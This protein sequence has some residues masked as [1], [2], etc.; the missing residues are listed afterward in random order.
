MNYVVVAVYMAI[1]IGIGWYAKQRAKT[2]S[3][4]LVAGRRLGPVLYGGTMGALVM[5]GGATVGGIGLG[6]Q[7]GISGMWLAFS[8]G[9]GV[10]V[11]SLTI[12][13][14]VSRLKVYTVSQMLEL[15]YGKGAAVVSGV[16]MLGY[17]FMISVTSTIAYGTIFEVLFGIGKAPAVIFGGGVV[18]L[19][20]VLGGMWS[21]T[22]TDFVQFIIKTV[23]IFVI[24]LPASLIAVGGFSG[25]KASLP[26][27][28]FDITHIGL[29]TI[30]SYLIIYNLS[31]VI[32]QDV[33]QRVFT[34]RS[35]K[36]AKWAGAA[37]GIYCFFYAIAGAFIGMAAK[38]L[39]PDIT[40]RNTVYGTIV[41]H[42]LPVGL[43]GLVLA[44]ALAAI[45]STSSGALIASATVAKQ[46]IVRAL[47]R[48]GIKSEAEQQQESHDEVRD[49]RWYILGFGVLM[50]ALA[51][52]LQ[53]VVA[54]ITIAS[55]I[56]VTGLFVP[57][58]GGM[59]WKRATI[60]GVIFS[61]AAGIVVTFGHMA[62]VR[63]VYSD[64]SIFYGMGA[65]L[66]AYVVGSLVTSPTSPAVMAEWKRRAAKPKD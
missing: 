6:Y 37:A 35:D 57:V 30:F 16:V 32:G 13:S 58:I 3:D 52:A 62:Y 40:D 9:A 19:Y 24:L 55:A 10:V 8:L 51:A 20:A 34:A 17:A 1:M 27:T 41:E 65:S 22:L 25:L 43:S 33:W 31:I 48:R 28:A 56:V 4:F 50:I 11:V 66:V 54:A 2:E 29:G 39:L 59:I 44:A 64:T 36:V 15:R 61:I 47:R 45:M 26:E 7:Y 60:K 46:D 49:S 5:G 21:I 18:V 12:A 42:V 23:G 63:D 38:V 53:D 14:L